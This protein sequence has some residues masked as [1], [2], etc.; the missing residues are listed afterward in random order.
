MK[1]KIKDGIAEIRFW[2]QLKNRMVK[3]T[4]PT[5]IICKECGK[6]IKGVLAKNSYSFDFYHPECIKK[7]VTIIYDEMATEEDPE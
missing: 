4:L 1:I 5:P 7:P 6:E 2:N 3:I